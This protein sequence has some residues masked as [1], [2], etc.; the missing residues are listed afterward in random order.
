M[1]MTMTK[2]KTPAHTQAHTQAQ[3]REKVGRLRLEWNAGDL[4]EG[5][6][7]EELVW[8]RED[9]NRDL[10]RIMSSKNIIGLWG[11]M[12]SKFGWQKRDGRLKFEAVTGQELISKLLP[13]TECRFKVYNYGP[14]LAIQ[15]WHHDQPTGSEWYY[16]KPLSRRAFRLWQMNP[17]R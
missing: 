10:T 5:L 9:F 4:G 8:A 2:I 12:V 14:G 16:I 3:I 17:A 11:A 7:G 6:S 1:T 13:N 15:N